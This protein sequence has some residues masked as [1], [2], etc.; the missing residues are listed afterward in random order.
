[1]NL[2]LPTKPLRKLV[3]IQGISGSIWA[4]SSE[5]A[6]YWFGKCTDL[7]ASRR[8][9]RALRLLLAAD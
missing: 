3:R 5:K 9:E 2:F 4:M 7:L 6:Y 1:M 8:A